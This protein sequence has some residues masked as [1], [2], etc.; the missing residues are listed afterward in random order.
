MENQALQ[1]TLFGIIK[2]Y[3]P[4]GVDFNSITPESDFLR[5]LKINSAHLV[6]IVLDIEEAFDIQI[7]DASMD[8]M[9]TVSDALRII[10]T[11]LP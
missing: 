10:E 1:E 6:D 11:K 2:P 5:D 8:S 7:D 3:L 4:Q 9:K